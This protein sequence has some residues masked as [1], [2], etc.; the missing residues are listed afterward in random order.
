MVEEIFFVEEEKKVIVKH[1]VLIVENQLTVVDSLQGLLTS[2]GYDV[3]GFCSKGDDVLTAYQSLQPDIVFVDIM[4]EG[5]VTG[6]DVIARIREIG[7]PMVIFSA[8]TL[9]NHLFDEV[10]KIRPDGFLTKPFN[11][12]QLKATTEIA[13]HRFFERNKEMTA[14]KNTNSMQ[15]MNIKELSE[16][17]A[18]L[19]VAT[20][21]ERELK[22][23][24]QET[25]RII[26]L[27]NKR[28]LDSINYAQRIQQAIIPNSIE[29]DKVIANHFMVYKAKDVV[30]GDFPWVFKKG[31][32]T[33][34]G[35][36]DCTGH[37]VPGAMLS[38]IGYLLLNGIVSNSFSTPATILKELHRQMVGILKQDIEGNNASDGMDIALCRINTEQNEVMYS[39]AHRPLYHLSNGEVFQYKGD[40]FPIGGIQYK[41]E[42]RF[43]D[44]RV[45][46]NEGESIYFF[47]DG[48]PDQFG[49]DNK[50][51]F[52]SK[53]IRNILTENEGKSMPEMKTV[54]EKE[55]DYWMKDE[56]QLDDILMVGVKF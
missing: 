46:V 26:A 50:R 29:I 54:F 9:E 48:L 19:V 53:R 11:E 18:H 52:G 13:L 17:N 15:S 37:G 2:F 51:K 8:P 32:Y 49:G 6:I 23:E 21:R 16:T 36:V 24:L 45:I 47:S 31:K 28:I 12:D 35:A 39:G 34:F 10:K 40:R 7:N 25:H 1:K 33:Y 27:Q 56:K 3:V 5:E 14:L 41:G 42:Y 22:K 43:T 55:L 38:M 44:T 30:S 20:W 4:M